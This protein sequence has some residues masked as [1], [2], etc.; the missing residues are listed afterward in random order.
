MADDPR[1]YRFV[2][3]LLAS[4]DPAISP[5]E[6]HAHIHDELRAALPP[7]SAD[8]FVIALHDPVKNYVNFVYFEAPEGYSYPL[9]RPLS[10]SGGLSDWVILN[11]R[12]RLWS[13]DDAESLA[14]Q[15]ANPVQARYAVPLVLN[16]RT[17]G[18]MILESYEPGFRFVPESLHFFDQA[19]R[20]VSRLYGIYERLRTGRFIIDNPDFP[21]MVCRIQDGRVI[22]ANWSI[23]N[24]LGYTLEES[25]GRSFLDFVAERD[26]ATVAERYR[27]RIQGIATDVRYSA[28]YLAKDGTEV[29]VDVIVATGDYYYGR[30]AVIVTCTDL[31][32]L[33]RIQSEARDAAESS[34]RAKSAFLA[35]MSHEIRT[36]MNAILGMTSILQQGGPTP[37]QAERLDKIDTAARHLL[38][39]INGILDLSKIEAGKFVLDDAPVAIDSLL[40]NVRSIMAEHAQS[41][42]LALKV[43]SEHFPANLFGDMTRLQQALLNYV[44]NAIKF[45]VQGTIT[46][47][48]RR[49][50]EDSES[51]LVRFEVEDTGLGIAPEAQAR[52]FRAF[53]QADNSITR[54]FGG[55]GLG[56]TITRRL[57]ELMGGEVGLQSTPGVGSTFWLTARLLKKERRSADSPRDNRKIEA[58]L[59]ERHLGRRIL[60]VDDDAMNLEVACLL[61]ESSQL[62]VDTADDGTQAIDKARA[63]PYALILMDMQMPVLDGLEATRRI[64][65]IPAH[66]Y[67][68]ILAMTANA[69]SEDKE[70]CFEAGMNDF[71]IK[72][73][74]PDTLFHAL[75]KWLET[76]RT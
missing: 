28:H 8:A 43:D 53:E 16:G 18:A 33:L 2:S 63:T 35:N 24:R 3:N 7:H 12:S 17:F 25:L 65:Q 72:P 68:P 73:M 22:D 15:P 44:T 60:V 69:F 34:N 52:V 21:F 11:G 5:A 36:P 50:E 40:A 61:L 71:L 70:R 14:L 46:L 45:T 74:N 6:L 39:I 58:L 76:T 27:L 13:A 20:E 26:R 30:P 41:K 9:D 38:S 57:A 75:L 42:G 55:T 67:T 4:I 10:S 59:K 62:L 49:Q 48:A 51:L 32:E 29:P 54:N 1:L 56:L 47:R 31:S 23:R 37:V 66:Q 19:I 64:R